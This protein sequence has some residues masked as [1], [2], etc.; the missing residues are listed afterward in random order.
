MGPTNLRTIFYN[1]SLFSPF[2]STLVTCLTQIKN[3]TCTIYIKQTVGKLLLSLSL[4]RSGFSIILLTGAEVIPQV[5][6]SSILTK[7][8]KT[9]RVRGSCMPLRAFC[10][11][12][13]YRFATTAPFWIHTFF[14]FSRRE[15]HTHKVPLRKPAFLPNQ[16]L[17][18]PLFRIVTAKCISLRFVFGGWKPP[19]F[20]FVA[21]LSP[22][23]KGEYYAIPKAFPG[24]DT[25][26]IRVRPPREII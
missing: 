6:P 10:A 24:Y 18:K 9:K 2:I 22:D 4:F 5:F 11:T 13:P 23:N 26:S 19:R 1:F 20:S 17:E 15:T 3:F 12:S 21:D 25:K 14:I 16:P 8:T 7:N